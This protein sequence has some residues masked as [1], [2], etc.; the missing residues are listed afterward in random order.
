MA[1]TLRALTKLESVYEEYVYE[2][3][4]KRNGLIGKVSKFI[5]KGCVVKH[6]SDVV[7]GL[8]RDNVDSSVHLG[9]N[10]STNDNDCMTSDV[11]CIFW[12]SLISLCQI[13]IHLLNV[14]YCSHFYG[15]PLWKLS[16]K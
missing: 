11:I 15:E 10:I 14:T 8:E 9:Y 4:V 3:C 1:Q 12:R 7:N 5:G 13:F 16:G 2:Y 6:S